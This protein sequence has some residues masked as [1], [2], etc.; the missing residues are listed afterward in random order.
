VIYKLRTTIIVI[1]AI[2][3]VAISANG[4]SIQSRLLTLGIGASREPL[5]P[6]AFEL[7]DLDGTAHSLSDHLG[8]VVFLNFWAT[9]CGPCRIEMPSMERLHRKFKDE[10]FEILAVD[11]QESKDQVRRF[12]DE[13]DLTFTILLD[14]TGTVGAQYGARS[15][16]TTYLIDREG[17]IFARAIG[18]REW[19]TPQMI[20]LFRR[21]LREGVRY[22]EFSK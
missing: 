22:E 3:L 11:L 9:W 7:E 15:I 4:Q 20:D 2:G 16:P 8:K 6:I 19:D 17:N 21:I 18:A 13:L 12:A 10:G 5:E 1:I 14:K